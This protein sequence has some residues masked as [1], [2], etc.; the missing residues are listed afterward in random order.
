MHAA[1]NTYVKTKDDHQ[2][3]LHKVIAVLT[4]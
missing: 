3:S 1:P 2:Q 4:W